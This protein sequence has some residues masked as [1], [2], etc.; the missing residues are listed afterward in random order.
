MPRIALTEG[1]SAPGRSRDQYLSATQSR[2]PPDR[3]EENGQGL[4]LAPSCYEPNRCQWVTPDLANQMLG[5]MNSRLGAN[6]ASFPIHCGKQMLI[7]Q[8]ELAVCFSFSPER[9]TEVLSHAIHEAT[10]VAGGVA[11]R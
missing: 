7:P 9:G 2:P 10:I 4:Q 5:R 8:S 11:G 3:P 1:V 6:G